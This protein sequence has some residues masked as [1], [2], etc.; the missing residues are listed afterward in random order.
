MT[1]SGAIK[2]RIPA[3][4]TEGNYA[5]PPPAVLNGVGPPVAKPLSIRAI[6]E[7]PRAESDTLVSAV[8]KIYQVVTAKIAY[9]EREAQ[10]LRD[11]LKPFA[12]ISPRPAAATDNEISADAIRAV[13]NIA[14]QLNL[15]G[16]TK[17]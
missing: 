12:A 13:L 3:Y 16:D 7:P 9:H 10:K 11:S 14:D 4:K 17:P 15:N 8:A 5:T 6:E 2:P 1:D